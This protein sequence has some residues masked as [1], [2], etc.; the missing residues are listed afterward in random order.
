MEP[1]TLFN[2]HMK[3]DLRALL[4]KLDMLTDRQFTLSK[5]Q[6]CLDQFMN[7]TNL[8]TYNTPNGVDYHWSLHYVIREEDFTPEVVRK[9][10]EDHKKFYLGNMDVK[11]YLTMSQD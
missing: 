11:R 7:P 1:S 8:Y 9:E 6:E 3:H 10:F 4:G 2:G 5:W